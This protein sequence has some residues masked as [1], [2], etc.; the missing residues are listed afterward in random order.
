MQASLH[1]RVPTNTFSASHHGL[2]HISANLFAEHC[3]IKSAIVCYR[4]FG[5]FCAKTTTLY[6]AK[7]SYESF[8]SLL[9]TLPTNQA[10]PYEYSDYRNSSGWSYIILGQCVCVR[11]FVCVG[12]LRRISEYQLLEFPHNFL[13]TMECLVCSFCFLGVSIL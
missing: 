12:F 13:D 2:K 8:R 3:I 9:F 7:L 1:P 5:N 6:G 11:V 10:W 4:T